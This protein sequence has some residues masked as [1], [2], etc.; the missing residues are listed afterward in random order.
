MLGFSARKK[1]ALE[2]L[3]MVIQKIKLIFTMSNCKQTSL[4]QLLLITKNNSKST[5]SISTAY[6]KL[7]KL[8]VYKFCYALD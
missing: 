8:F 2:Y 3:F 7:H 4:I 5:F 6:N 1:T